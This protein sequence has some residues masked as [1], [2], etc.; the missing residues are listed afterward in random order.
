MAKSK[1]TLAQKEKIEDL[2][3]RGWIH[4][5]II[6]ELLGGPKEYITET[7]E[8]YVQRIKEDD[9]HVVLATE[10]APVEAQEKLWSTF[11]EIDLWVKDASTLAFLCFD[12]MPS[13]IEVIEPESLH[14]RAADF[15]AFFNDLQARLHKLD[16]IVKN[17]RAE[18]KVL[19]INGS[20]LLRNNVLISLKEKDK[21]LN[22][23]AKN[24]GLVPEQLEP[25]L[26]AMI[27]E[28]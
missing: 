25:F 1:A 9:A 4:C 11:A 2:L 6:V 23:L 10:I 21:D 3:E 7:I 15:A 27:K 5:R 24:V 13:S 17:L 20:R 16:M 12:Y 18:N 19:Q 14:Y 26:D 22:T 8:Q 28:D